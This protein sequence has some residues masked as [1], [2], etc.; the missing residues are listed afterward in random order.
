[1]RSKLLVIL[2][3]PL[4]A[5]L[6]FAGLRVREVLDS[7]RQAER[8]A[9]MARLNQRVVP[10]ARALEAER[11]ASARF[12]GSGR[13]DAQAAVGSARDLTDRQVA[14]LTSLSGGLNRAD[15]GPVVSAGLG[16]VQR[17]IGNLPHLRHSVDTDG[18]WPAVD[19]QYRDFVDDLLVLQPSITQGSRDPGLNDGVRAL[20]AVSQYVKALEVERGDIGYVLALDKLSAKAR[21]D[22]FHL[23]AEAAV[24][25]DMA[26]ATLTPTQR[27]VFDRTATGL[28]A[29]E[30]KR[31]VDQVLSI[32]NGEPIPVDVVTWYG[33]TGKLL[34]ALDSV[35]DGFTA[36]VLVRAQ[37]LYYQARRQAVIDG[38]VVLGVLLLTVVFAWLTVRSLVRPLRRLRSRALDVAYT[39]LP[40]AVARMRDTNQIEAGTAAPTGLG[41]DSRDEVG[42]VAEAFDSVYRE[43]VRHAA[44]QAQLRQNVSTMFVNLSRRT[45]SLVERQ[46][47]LIDHLEGTERDPDNLENLFQLDHLATRM[48]RNAENLLVLAGADP[49]RRWNRPVALIDVLR[50][51]AAEVEQYR[52]VVHTFVTGREIE[53]RAVGDIVHLVAELLENAS[54]FSPP[55]THVVVSARSMSGGAG[56]TIEIEDHGIGMPPEELAAA[57][58][59]LSPHA[60]LEPQASRI[61][62]LYVVGRLAA[63]H[64]IQVQLRA[65]S[66]GGIAA[67]IHLPPHVVVDLMAQTGTEL[68]PMTSSMPPTAMGDPGPAR[69]QPAG[70]TGP[71]PGGADPQHAGQPAAG[72][73]SVPAA[74]GAPV[75]PA[76][77][78]PDAPPLPRRRPSALLAEP[79]GPVGTE[80]VGAG[81]A[82]EQAGPEQAGPERAGPEQPG[83]EQAGP[84]RAGPEQPEQVGPEQG[85]QVGPEQPGPEQAGP[86]Q[87]GDEPADRSTD[88]VPA[89]G[90]GGAA[91]RDQRSG[92]NEDTIVPHG[93]DEDLPIF[94][95]LESRWFLRRD[96]EPSPSMGQPADQP[97]SGHADH[98]QPRVAGQ[99]GPPVHQVGGSQGQPATSQPGSGRAAAAATP[100]VPGPVE[101]APWASPADVG[102][103]AAQRLAGQGPGSTTS[104]GLPVRVPMAHFVPGAVP[105]SAPTSPAAPAAGQPGTRSARHRSP[106]AVRGMLASF[107]RGLRQ[108]REAGRH[109]H[110]DHDESPYAN[111]EHA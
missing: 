2:L 53:G 42:E 94:A 48:R 102:W 109:R 41:I 29:E 95:E 16:S 100:L 55:E 96:A 33:S 9:Q 34:G 38:A 93:T 58:E 11:D 25:R 8:A 49:G 71:D 82:G 104:A 3:V 15:L 27:A 46:L 40:G 54:E 103:R 28:L 4:L 1:V 89:A 36:Q 84:E 110:N 20:A 51:A 86:E 90:V 44:E 24:A 99:P 101:P 52:R 6:G 76:A 70:A 23:D 57:N 75:G 14:G 98:S 80:P 21:T 43:A 91:R 59:R 19:G 74:S 92:F 68:A 56:V 45:Q 39:D 77:G 5:V 26:R 107:Q 97:G 47:R 32:P 83:P 79:P 67:L 105:A 73:S 106:D 108:G 81:L 22:A 72:P 88:A 17:R 62:G 37:D 85:E 78:P 31:L 87:A 50:A 13:R 111:Q 66:A 7:A 61:M 64:G 30:V 18:G 69:L 10:L 65:A 60:E 12:I 35:E 63:R